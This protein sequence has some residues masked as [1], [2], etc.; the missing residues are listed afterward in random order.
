MPLLS[1]WRLVR[2]RC[3]ASSIQ[4][5][6]QLSTAFG[7]TVSSRRYFRRALKEAAHVPSA[8]RWSFGMLLHPGLRPSPKVGPRPR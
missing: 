6:L 4:A 7:L 2:S 5:T 8:D 3:G 1:A